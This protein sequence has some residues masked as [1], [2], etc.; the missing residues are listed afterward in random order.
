MNK[1]ILLALLFGFSPANIASALENGFYAVS[2]NG[3]GPLVK[4]QGHDYHAGDKLN[5]M[6]LK[7]EIRSANNANT[8]FHLLMTVPIEPESPWFAAFLLDGIYYGVN[9]AGSDLKSHWMRVTI[10]S[11]EIAEL[12][13]KYFNSKMIL[14]RYPGHELEVFFNP[15]DEESQ[16][17][18]PVSVI[19]HIR[20]VGKDAV[21][22]VEG[23][24]DRAPRDNQYVFSCR[25]FGKQVDDIGS[26][27]HQGGLAFTRSLKPGEVYEKGID[28]KK[29]FAFD[30]PGTYD[31]LGSFYMEFSDPNK[32]MLPEFTLW[33]D[34]ATADFR[35]IIR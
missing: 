27:S 28:L 14:R 29:W 3:N 8:Q 23:G 25:L 21:A 12:A 19:F 26:S 32:N 15:I 20:N 33:T 22:F 17:W 24:R 6:I 30:K 2:Q 4:I 35:I 5:L 9:R 16:T 34:Y 31:C 10:N 7:T 18:Q 1:M 13:T 11:R